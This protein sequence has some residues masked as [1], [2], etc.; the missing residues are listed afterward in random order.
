MKP[1]RSFNLLFMLLILTTAG[2][3]AGF[4]WFLFWLA[5]QILALVGA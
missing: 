2:A 3:I 4:L 1:D 5:R